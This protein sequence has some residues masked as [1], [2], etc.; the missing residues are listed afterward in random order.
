MRVPLLIPSGQQSVYL[1]SLTDYNP[2]IWLDGSQTRLGMHRRGN[3]REP[4]KDTYTWDMHR[5]AENL[6]KEL[7]GSGYNTISPLSTAWRPL[8]VQSYA[9]DAGSG[10]Y[11]PMATHFAVAPFTHQLASG[12][13]YSAQLATQ[14]LIPLYDGTVPF[15]YVSLNYAGEVAFRQAMV[16]PGMPMLLGTTAPASRAYGPVFLESAS[17]QVS[18]SGQMSPVQINGDWKGGK[19]IRVPLMPPNAFDDGDVE[20]R[21]FANEYR[22]ATMLDC[23]FDTTLQ[24]TPDDLAAS[25]SNSRY[26][27]YERIVGLSLNMRQAVSFNYTCPTRGKTDAHGPRFVSVSDR[28][29]TGSVTFVGRDRE[30]LFD[31]M[32]EGASGSVTM[33][34]GGSFL[35]PMQNVDWQKPTTNIVAGQV[36]SVTYS[37]VAR[38]CDYAVTKGFLPDTAGYPVSEFYISTG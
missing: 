33:Y 34:F 8:F 30:A 27:D 4:I 5:L 29:V 17:I 18:G 37:F 26:W 31:G 10:V 16:W 14:P 28:V 3:G 6:S 22:S 2:G 19:V 24:L 1:M 9:D 12:H 38:A 15:P 13:V 21:G 35:F 23:G 11:K 32:T 7:N 20:S 36:Y 25:M